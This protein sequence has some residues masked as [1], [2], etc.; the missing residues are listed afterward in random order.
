MFRIEPIV[1]FILF[2]VVSV[3]QAQSVIVKSGDTL[4]GL[5]ERFGIT[6]SDLQQANSDLSSTL[7]PG[8]VLRLPSDVTTYTVQSDDNLSD[9]AQSLGLTLEKLMAANDL[10][11]TTVN[12]GTVLN[13]S[14]LLGPKSYTVKSGDTLYDIALLVS[15][16]V[17]RLISLNDLEG[18]LIQP[19]Q[20]LVLSGVTPQSAGGP[21]VTTVKPGDTL[22]NLART[23]DLTVAAIQ[24]ANKLTSEAVLLPGDQLTIPG[25]FSPDTHDL[26]AAATREVTVRKGDTLTDLAFSFNTSVAALISANNLQTTDIQAGQRLYIVSGDELAPAG[27]ASVSNLAAGS[28]L[29]PINGVITSRFGYR[30]L[31]VNGSNFHNALDIDG[32]TGDPVRAAAAGTVTFSGWRGSYGN[33]VVVR[34]GDTE[35]R[36]AHNS[37]LLVQEGDQV[38]VSET[39]ALVGNTGLSFGDHLHFEVRVAGTPVDPL[40][41]LGNN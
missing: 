31:R 16:P 18:E 38:A 17:A 12:P 10:T 11:S 1:L 24:E 23:H 13:L 14:E 30:S 6:S 36:Y 9:V 35:Y 5:A 19:G 22:W 32:V 4:W 29:W 37:E 3:V 33:L 20:I 40:P 2:C 26:G 39:L 25:H 27:N 15:V 21:L 28:L 41:L 8:D 34:S 7:R